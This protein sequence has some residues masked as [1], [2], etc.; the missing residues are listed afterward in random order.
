MNKKSWYCIRLTERKHPKVK[1][2]LRNYI[3][4]TIPMAVLLMVLIAAI[5]F[6]DVFTPYTTTSSVSFGAVSSELNLFLKSNPL[7]ANL[8][9][10][11]LTAFNAFLIGQLNN[12]HTI[13][14]TRSFL[15]VMFFLLLM[16]CWHETHLFIS[17]HIALSFFI[18]ALFVIF[19]VYRNRSA[20]E[21]AFLSSFLIAVASI[22]FLPVILFIPLIWA[23]LILFHSFSLRN[24]LATFI[25]VIAPWIIYIAVRYYY[26]PDL[27]WLISLTD[28][29]E[30]GLPLLTRPLNEIIYV[31]ALFI[32][33][34]LGIAGLTSNLNQDSMQTR[35]FIN[36]IL[37]LLILSFV[38][39]MIF[40]N[41]FMIFMPFVGFSYAILLSHPLTLK[42]SKFYGYVFIGFIAVNL[43]FVIS[44]II[45]AAK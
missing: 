35:S 38:F 10:L 37:W 22:M 9:S 18:L 15:P 36:F 24:L 42:K 33:L 3:V 44:N 17:I 12:R 14:R 28:N 13:I 16:S 45:I 31:I 40:K 41:Y 20:S 11:L 2:E 4:P 26:Q 39:S 29:F 6:A 5:W 7:F 19:G 43:A 32:V 21:Q 25:G 30:F 27:S 34:V 8:I 23:G 1:I